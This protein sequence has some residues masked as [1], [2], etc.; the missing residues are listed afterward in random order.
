MSFGK[1]LKE[2]RTKVG[3]QQKELAER[4]GVSLRT[5]QN[6]EGDK[7]RPSHFEAVADVAKVLGV[8]SAELL[9]ENDARVIEAAEKGGAKGKR[10]VEALIAEVSGLFAG[11]ELDEEEK[12]G[13]I[14]A[15]NQAYWEAREKNRKYTPKKYKESGK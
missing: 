8:S 1:R 10:D 15:L 14:A 9:S 6:W 3:L 4:S 13:V 2:A 7:R 5:I 12:E 11:G